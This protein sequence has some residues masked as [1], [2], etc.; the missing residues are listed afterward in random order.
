MSVREMLSSGEGGFL[1]FHCR[2][3]FKVRGWSCET[4]YQEN[5]GQLQSSRMNE[6]AGWLARDVVKAMLFEAFL[7]RLPCPAGEVY[8]M[9]Y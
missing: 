2:A 1:P 9:M 5:Q 8:R 4:S 3:E 6:P 7:T